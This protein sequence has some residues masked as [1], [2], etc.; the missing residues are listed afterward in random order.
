MQAVDGGPAAN[1][2]TRRTGTTTV[3]VNV[4]DTNDNKPTLDQ[5]SYVQTILTNHSLLTAVLQANC[6]DPDLGQNGTIG[7]VSP[8]HSDFIVSNEG[9]VLLSSPQSDQTV[10]NFYLTCHDMGPVALSSSVLVTIVVNK[11]NFAA[12]VFESTAY[13]VSIPEDQPLLSTV[14]QVNAT[15]IWTPLLVLYTPLLV[16]TMATSSLSTLLLVQ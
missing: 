5:P 1:D 7:Y 14:V 9:L 2:S 12:P 8:P 4:L 10:H 6:S 13:N 11:I 15:T 3:T 16:E